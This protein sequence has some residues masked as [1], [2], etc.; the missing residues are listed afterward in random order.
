[1]F[2]YYD[3]SGMFGIW[4][5]VI[6]VSCIISIAIAVWVYRDAKERDMNETMWLLI[7]LL[8]GCIGCIIYLIVRE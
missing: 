3:I 6:V 1:M 8:T 5:A 4:I 2:Q 7:I